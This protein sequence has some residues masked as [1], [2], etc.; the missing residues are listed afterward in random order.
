MSLQLPVPYDVRGKDRVEFYVVIKSI[1][2]TK[3]HLSTCSAAYFRSCC[4]VYCDSDTSLLIL[5][6]LLSFLISHPP[7]LFHC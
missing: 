5:L 6:Q 7:L 3:P 2:N 1:I 4:S